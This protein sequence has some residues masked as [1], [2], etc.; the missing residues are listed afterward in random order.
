[1]KNEVYYP[2][3]DNGDRIKGFHNTYKR[4]N[5]DK[6]ATARTTYNGSVSPHNNVHPGRGLKDGTYSNPRVLSFLETFIVP[7]IPEN[8]NLPDDA[9]DTFIRTIIGEAIPLSC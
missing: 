9:S 2:K 3:K 7:M 8:I 6:P 5:W 1:M 4:M